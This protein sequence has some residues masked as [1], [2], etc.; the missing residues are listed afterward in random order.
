L[1]EVTAHTQT[2]HTQ[3]A[4]TQTA[5][6]QTAHTQTAHAQIANTQMHGTYTKIVSSVLHYERKNYYDNVVGI[7]TH[8]VDKDVDRRI[9]LR[10]IFRN[11]GLGLWTGLSWLR[12]ETG[13]GHL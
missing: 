5:H 4:H 7:K 10:R 3:T 6:A 1:V 9:I 2:A 13:G 12:I 11:W 8:L